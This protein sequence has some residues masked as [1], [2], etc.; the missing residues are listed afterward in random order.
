M[1]I[2]TGIKKVIKNRK[3][4]VVL[5]EDFQAFRTIIAKALIL[6]DAFQYLINIFNSLGI[7]SIGTLHGD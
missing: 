3:A 5:K 1:I 7:F 4:R 2:I 6:E